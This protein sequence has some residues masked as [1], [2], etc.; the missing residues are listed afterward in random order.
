MQHK[1]NIFFIN[2]NSKNELYL[3]TCK[4]INILQPYINILKKKT[5]FVR[6]RFKIDTDSISI[7]KG[8]DLLSHINAVPSALLGLT[9]LF[10][11]GRGE[12][13]CYNHPKLFELLKL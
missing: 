11:M 10:G 3:I 2:Y 7:K 5:S 8:S 1:K 13:Q 9:S 6:M 12:P 4:F